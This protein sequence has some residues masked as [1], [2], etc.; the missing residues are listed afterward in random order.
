VIS[1]DVKSYAAA[2]GESVPS[3]AS[4]VKNDKVNAELHGTMQQRLGIKA[5]NEMK[6]QIQRMLGPLESNLN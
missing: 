6:H 3:S 1:A 4:L 5:W 2:L